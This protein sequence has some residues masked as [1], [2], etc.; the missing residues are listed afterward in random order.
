[1]NEVNDQH[2]VIK[3]SYYSD[4]YFDAVNF[5]LTPAGAQ[6]LYTC[7]LETK[8]FVLLRFNFVYMT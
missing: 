1:M 2:C 8:Y 4:N 5:K 7:L 3:E 6:A